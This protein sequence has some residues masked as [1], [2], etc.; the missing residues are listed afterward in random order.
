MWTTVESKINKHTNNKF[1]MKSNKNNIINELKLLNKYYPY[2]VVLFGS[3]ARN[4]H[5]SESDIDILI[6]WNKKVPNNL[7]D[8]KK[9]L[10]LKFNKKV[11]LISMIFDG[12]LIDFD[13]DNN[14][15]ENIIC[16]G[17][18]IIGSN[19]NDILLSKIYSKI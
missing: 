4:T 1:R 17:I 10:E 18:M 16:D 19:L 7:H 15:I 3:T 6:V 14:F 5:N 8:I 12:N 9:D 13:N 11:D 2:M